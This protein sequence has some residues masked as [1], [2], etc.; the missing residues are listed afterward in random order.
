MDDGLFTD[1]NTNIQFIFFQT[2]WTHGTKNWGYM[3]FEFNS[4]V[5]DIDI[6]F[7]SLRFRRNPG[8]LIKEDIE[9]KRPCPTYI[10]SSIQEQDEL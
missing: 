6:P 10:P 5:I 8:G 2:G 7:L 3:F 4:F 9:S 1:C